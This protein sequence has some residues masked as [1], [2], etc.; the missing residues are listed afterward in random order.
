MSTM[1]LPQSFGIVLAAALVFFQPA[2]AVSRQ[3]LPRLP[4]SL[5]LAVIGDSGNGRRAQY[6][7]AA[8]MVTARQRFSFELVLMVGDNLLGHQAAADFVTK[9]E[10]PYAPLLSSG[11]QFF[12]ALG[13]HDEP[14]NRYYPPFNMSGQRYHTFARQGV[15]FYVLDST[16]FDP[17]QGAWI[18]NALKA[19]TEE[20]KVCYLH[21]PLYSSGSLT[22][23]PSTSG[24]GSSRCS[25]STVCRSCSPVTI[26]STSA[27]SHRTAS[28]TSSW[29]RRLRQGPVS[30]REHRQLPA[31]QPITRT[32]A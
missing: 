1:P 26:T 18:E 6:E 21:H 13:N 7:L 15:R 19:A 8:Q 14:A 23:P 9:F 24:R 30:G 10:R 5:K 11:V 12:A 3:D 20:W 16:D 29:A 2:R 27:S 17:E 25:S 31:P 32:S 22:D 4:D 28:T